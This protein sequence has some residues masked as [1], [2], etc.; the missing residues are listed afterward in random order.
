M[1]PKQADIRPLPNKK[2]VIKSLSLTP[3]REEV[4][5]YE[6]GKAVEISKKLKEMGSQFVTVLVMNR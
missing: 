3:Q 2:T 4:I 6:K 5:L 1:D